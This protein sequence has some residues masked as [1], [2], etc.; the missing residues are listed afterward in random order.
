LEGGCTALIAR[1]TVTILGGAV[2]L[3]QSMPLSTLFPSLE[4]KD[5]LRFVVATREGSC[6]LWLVGT[7]LTTTQQVTDF[8]VE[9][10]IDQRFENKEDSPLEIEYRFPLVKGVKVT[11][12]YA[13]IDGRKG[14][15]VVW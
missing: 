6:Y 13:E 9:V 14:S 5:V 1:K 8:S 15:F 2:C 12:F 4:P 7:N 10:T 11:D 3:F